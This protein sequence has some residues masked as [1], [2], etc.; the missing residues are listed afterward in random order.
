LFTRV[1]HWVPS[2]SA[3]KYEAKDGVPFSKW[4]MMKQ[5]RVL[6]SLRFKEQV[7]RQIFRYILRLSK[8]YKLQAVCYDQ[9]R[10]SSIITRLEREGITCIPVEQKLGPLSPACFELEGR[11]KD[12]MIT[13]FPNECLRWEASNVEVYVDTN[14]NMRP[15]KQA[16]K[17]SYAGN[18]GAKIDGIAALVTGLTQ[19]V[20]REVSGAGTESVKDLIS[21][22]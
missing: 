20:R 2:D 6:P 1:M 12:Q 7:K 4:E 17:G 18:R 13:I 21:F 11:L 8:K 22:M 9:W 3:E 5:I 10:A 15:I 16:A 14:G 19:I